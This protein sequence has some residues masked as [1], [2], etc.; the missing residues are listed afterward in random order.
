MLQRKKVLFV[1]NTL[2]HGGAE[3][4][5]IQFIRKFD[6]ER[7]AL[8]LYV[9]LGQGELIRRVPEHVT[10]LNRNYSDCD[11]LSH[12]GKRVLIRR[13]L[14]L[15]LRRGALLRNLPFLLRNS[16]M[17]RGEGAHHP[18]KLLWQALVDGCPALEEH[19]DFGV[20][21]L[22][23]ASTYF[24]D[25]KVQADMKAAFVHTDYLRA[26]YTPELD[27]GAYA[28]MDRIY[29]VSEETRNSFLRVYPEYAEKT[30]VFYNIIDCTAALHKGEHACSFDT[31]GYSGLR[32]VSLGRLIKLKAVDKSIQAMRI[33]K[34]NG[35]KVR[36]YVFGEGNA[37][38]YFEK[39][40]EQYGVGDCF[41][42]PG[43]VENPFPYLKRAAVYCQCSAYEGRSIA[44]SEAQLMGCPVI[45][46][47][48]SGSSG[49]ITDGV[50][51]LLVTPTPENSAAAI[52]KLL[53]DAPLRQRLGEAAAEKM[54][55]QCDMG[56]FARLEALLDEGII[57]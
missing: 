4:A 43:T 7:Y 3:S 25:R 26:G 31:D 27:R 21:Y 5:L 51:G 9:V 56:D 20:A 28:R 13:T 11:V 15:L 39:L 44:I 12:R 33:L 14:R 45:A 42:L 22:E 34:D 48:C 50:D 18:E 6:P 32:I 23:G 8:Y 2:G 19:F 55:S 40:I 46:S 36:W 24:L 49:Q 17:L 30:D 52:Q 29:C 54:S 1:I 35:K 37:R 57:I 41:F 53:D 38:A 47:D 10:L 16:G